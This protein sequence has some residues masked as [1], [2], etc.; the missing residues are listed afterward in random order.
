MGLAH[1]V[2]S[3]LSNSLLRG[4]P[5]PA[6]DIRALFIYLYHLSFHLVPLE[7]LLLIFE[8]KQSC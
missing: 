7:D 5:R 4:G 1:H 2:N 3:R 6:W 8:Q